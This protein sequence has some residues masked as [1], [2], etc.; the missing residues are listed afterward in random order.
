MKSKA[1]V[2]ISLSFTLFSGC[3]LQ[4]VRSKSKVGNEWRHSGSRSTNEERYSVEQGFDFKWDKGIGTGIS[5]RRRDINEGNGDNDT[6]L[7]LDFSFPVWKAPPPKKESSA[8]RILELERRV[9][10]LEGELQQR[11]SD[12]ARSVQPTPAVADSRSAPNLQG[13]IP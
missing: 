6:G 7:W 13:E 3:A 9:A 2:G 8:E 11:Q 4:E 1:W 12:A 10:L 5:V